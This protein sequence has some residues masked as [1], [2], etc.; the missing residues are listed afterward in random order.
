MALDSLYYLGPLGRLRPLPDVFSPVD[1][2]LRRG[3]ASHVSL[4]GHAVDDVMWQRRAWSWDW[5]TMLPVQVAYVDALHAGLVPGPLRLIDPRRANRLPDYVASGGSTRGTAA[6]FLA[7]AGTRSYVS[8]FTVPADEDTLGPVGMVL[9]AT[10]WTNP[11]TAGM[12]AADR[13]VATSPWWVPLLPG[14]TVDCFAWVAADAAATVRPTYQTRTAAGVVATTTVPA[15]DEVL[16]LGEWSK[17]A[18][19][20]TAGAGIVALCPG[21]APT[22]DLTGSLYTTG[23]Q[24]GP[25]DAETMPPMSAY[26]CVDDSTGDPSDG[27]RVGGGGPVVRVV[28]D[29]A[30]SYPFPQFHAAALTVAEV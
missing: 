21:I 2:G 12:F 19:Q 17:V 10:K 27:W 18:W 24:V 22:S 3:V 20:V 16:T 28:G 11:T 7:A 9:G 8:I 1:A 23:W 30:H 6:G 25:P 15:A 26:D 4:G 5:A 13:Y 29:G 14:E